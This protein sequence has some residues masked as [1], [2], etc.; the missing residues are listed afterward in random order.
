MAVW[1]GSTTFCGIKAAQT[2]YDLPLWE[3][4][5]NAHPELKMVIELGTLW[6]G[7]S[8]FLLCQC[9]NRGISFYTAD[10]KRPSAIETPLGKILELDQH[11]VL[12]DLLHG[13]SPWLLDT[14]TTP[15]KHPLLLYCDNGLKP[16]EFT[17]YAPYLQHND[18]VGLHDWGTEIQA[19]DINLSG[20]APEFEKR[21]TLGNSPTRFFRRL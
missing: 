7:F 9:I 14:L 19:T 18:I 5:L 8:L 4:F 17:M 6:G 20:F 2:H 13:E 11:F 3:D 16:L 10:H 1:H 21:C 15:Q 12:T